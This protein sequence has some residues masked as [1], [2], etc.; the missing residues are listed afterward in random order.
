MNTL[1]KLKE[2]IVSFYGLIMLSKNPRNTKY[3]FIIGNAQD[4]LAEEFRTKGQIDN[5]FD[6]KE[7]ES[8]YSQGYHPPKY[9]LDEL[10]KLPINTL[11]Y[12]YA[13]HMRKNNLDPEY[14]KDTTPLHPMHYLRLRIRKTHDIWHLLCGYDTSLN[15]EMGL[16]GVYFAQF[17]NGQSA[18]ILAGGIFKALFAFN[19]KQLEDYIHYFI[20][21]YNKGKNCLPLLP[22][23]WEEYWN[24]DLLELRVK[25]NLT[26]DG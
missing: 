26:K 12:Q 22:V 17:T 13:D 8:L 16:Q 21:G 15:G 19:Y 1:S 18:M 6:N 14:Y 9:N 7:I 4:R 20:E 25:M 23:K 5:P 24:D 2:L 11:G 3:V 10:S